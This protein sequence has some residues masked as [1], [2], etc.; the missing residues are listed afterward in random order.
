MHV[1]NGDRGG[2]GDQCDDQA[3]PEHGKAGVGMG[4][5]QRAGDT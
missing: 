2:T 5:H 1:V 4:K 3:D